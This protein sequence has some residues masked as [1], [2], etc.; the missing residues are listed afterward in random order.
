MSCLVFWNRR[1]AFSSGSPAMH[2]K[3][4][5]LLDSG[6]FCVMSG[7][8]PTARKQSRNESCV[9]VRECARQERGRT[10]N[11][12]PPSRSCDRM[13]M[14]KSKR[15]LASGTQLRTMEQTSAS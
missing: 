13:L 3:Y 5:S 15:I 6:A 12:T 14:R 10:T 8:K 7:S 2:S 4:T 9:N 1:A 11:A